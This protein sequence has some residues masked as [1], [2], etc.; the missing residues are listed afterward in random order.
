[1]SSLFQSDPSLL[2][3][4]T[5]GKTLSI[6]ELELVAREPDGLLEID[7]K[8]ENWMQLDCEQA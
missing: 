6:P 3:L 8:I 4:L 2:L 7:D 1:M 5:R